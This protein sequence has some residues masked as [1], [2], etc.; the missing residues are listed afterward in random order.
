V[1]P[2]AAVLIVGD[3]HQH[4]FPLRA[5]LQMR[6]HIGDMLI[7]RRGIGI[8]GVLVKIPLRLEKRDLRERSRV[9]D[10]DEFGTLEFPR[11]SSV[12]HAL[13]CREPS[14]RNN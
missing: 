8:A 7:A 3:D 12:R 6:D 5:S 10:L 9:N 11:P 13:G 4:V 2:E 1:V 14:Q